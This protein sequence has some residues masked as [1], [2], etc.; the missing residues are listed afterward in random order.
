MAKNFEAKGLKGVVKR[1]DEL[2]AIKVSIGV[3][4]STNGSHADGTSN[5]TIAAAQELG[6]PGR[7]PARSHYRATLT[8]KGAEYS[9]ILAGQMNKILSGAERVNVVFSK[10]GVQI[11]NDVKQKI[12]SGI[13]PALDIKTIQRKGSSV[14]LIDTGQYLQS[15][16][17]EVRKK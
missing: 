1:L 7:I 3:I 10:M 12:I 13:S 14:P 16:T 17:Y 4:S 5:A 8:E 6:V 15:I 2:K 11:S 9:S